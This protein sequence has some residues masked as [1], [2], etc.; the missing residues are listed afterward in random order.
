MACHGQPLSF[1][2]IILIFHWLWFLLVSLIQ[3]KTNGEV[4]SLSSKLDMFRIRVVWSLCTKTPPDYH[5]DMVSPF[6]LHRMTCNSSNWIPNQPSKISLQR[7]LMV[8]NKALSIVLIGI[9][10]MQQQQLGLF[11]LIIQSWR[12]MYGYHKGKGEKGFI[13]KDR[14]MW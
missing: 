14:W 7:L 5:K 4:M 12:I 3:Q 8:L 6:V 10:F 13:L 11:S 9:L 2:H 1:F